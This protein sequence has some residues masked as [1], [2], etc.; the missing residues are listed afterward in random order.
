MMRLWIGS[1]AAMALS[2]CAASAA[3]PPLRI[4]DEATIPY[5]SSDGILDWKIASADTLYVR[6]MM[7]RWYLVRTQGP[8]PRL[9]SAGRVGFVTVGSDRLDRYGAIVAEGWRCQIASITLSAPPPPE[10][11]RKG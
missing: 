8:C 11:A 5:A 1:T 2:T 3:P 9:R 10:V 7:N 6:S 4:G